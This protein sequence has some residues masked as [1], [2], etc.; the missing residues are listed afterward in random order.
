MHG[1]VVIFRA[2][3]EQM[4]AMVSLVIA[5]ATGEKDARPV[6][7]ENLRTWRNQYVGWYAQHRGDVWTLLHGDFTPHNL[8]PWFREYPTALRLVSRVEGVEVLEVM[9][10]HEWLAKET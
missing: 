1:E 6:V 5:A 8:R 2:T 4:R 3:R 7:L 10:R 9:S